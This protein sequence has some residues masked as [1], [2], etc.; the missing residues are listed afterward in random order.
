MSNR[1]VF[2]LD[3]DPPD[4]APARALDFAGRSVAAFTTT[5]M[6]A[7]P[8]W[9]VGVHAGLVAHAQSLRGGQEWILH[10]S[11]DANWAPGVPF[12]ADLLARLLR[13]SREAS[14][15]QGARFLTR[16]VE[17]VLPYGASTVRL[18]LKRRIPFLP[19]ILSSDVFMEV[20]NGPYTLAGRR[21][22]AMLALVKNALGERLYPQAPA[23]LF[24]VVTRTPED[25]LRL[26]EQGV[27][28]VTCNPNLPGSAL[29]RYSASPQLRTG[30]LAMAGVLLSKC[31]EHTA[32]L[33]AAIRR[34]ALCEAVGE[35]VKPLHNLIDIF[36][37]EASE[38]TA[39]LLEHGL[40]PLKTGDTLTLAYADFTPNA[41]VV[42]CIADDLT[43]ML[44]VRVLLSPLAYHAYLAE[45]SEQQCD[46]I[47]TLIQPTFPEPVIFAEQLMRWRRGASDLEFSLL[48]SL[49]DG[50]LQSGYAGRVAACRAVL[51]DAA[52]DIPV[53]PILRHTSKCLVSPAAQTLRLSPDGLLRSSFNAQESPCLHY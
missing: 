14:A 7:Y 41:E 49:P 50:V 15:G 30:A 46:L 13:P 5:A 42:R 18:L 38:A 37:E 23:E 53:I 1:W 22:G 36:A 26:F 19:E 25:G 24:F 16:E 40:R 6:F 20:A 45:L 48:D 3:V 52:G 34:S 39:P 9:G 4:I 51:A 44:G 21:P 2:E 10:C 8:A 47:Y 29:Q 35:G 28:D 32:S 31:V 11:P 17:S 27:L 12:T 33:S 43:S